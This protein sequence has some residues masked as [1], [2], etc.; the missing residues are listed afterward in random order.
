MSD[1]YDRAAVVALG[2][3][4]IVAAAATVLHDT[5][6]TAVVW[7]I[8]IAVL[9]VGA[10]EQGGQKTLEDRVDE[11]MEAQQQEV[12]DA[13]AD[14][15]LDEALLERELDEVLDREQQR[16]RLVLERIPDVGER[17]SEAIVRAGFGSIDALRRAD[18]E[19]LQEVHGVGPSLAQTI[20]EQLAT[21]EAEE[22]KP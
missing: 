5:L 13:Y 6:W 7:L 14:G 9:T 21:A 16:T 11:R 4:V 18:P 3:L 19:E 15:P 20:P 22:R 8:G 1:G 10:R 2:G 12:R 17:T